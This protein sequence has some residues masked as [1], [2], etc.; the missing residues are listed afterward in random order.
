M[1]IDWNLVDS[2]RDARSSYAAEQDVRS[3]GPT[4]YF[5]REAEKGDKAKPET[6]IEDA[7]A[8]P[9]LH[10]RARAEKGRNFSATRAS[11]K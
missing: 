2:A 6:E 11:A 10:R 8:L 4:P 5:V 7:D 9:G 1:V 3:I